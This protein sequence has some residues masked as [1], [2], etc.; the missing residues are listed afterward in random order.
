ML[1]YAGNPASPDSLELRGFGRFD[2]IVRK[3]RAARNI[4]TNAPIA[5]P[6]TYQLRWKA[7]PDL[8]TKIKQ[9]GHA[10]R[11]SP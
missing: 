8:K 7:F 6:E 4:R 1:T 9:A 11:E 2:V 10:R 5:V 3:P